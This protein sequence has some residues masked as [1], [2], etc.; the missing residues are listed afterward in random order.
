MTAEREQAVRPLMN[1][2]RQV[3]LRPSLRAVFGQRRPKFS[4]SD[5]FSRRRILL[6]ALGKGSIG[7]EA[8]QLLGSIVVSHLWQTAL[9]RTSVPLGHRTPVMIYIDE[10][11]DYLRLPGDLSE[12]LAQARGLGVGFTLANQE[13]GQLKQIR[14]AV[15]ANTRSRVYFQ[16]APDDARDLAASFGGELLSREDFRALRQYQAYAQ[17]LD[18]GS[19]TPWVSLTTQALPRP[20]R[21]PAL[22]RRRSREHYGQSLDLVETDLLSLTNQPA[23]NASRPSEGEDRAAGPNDSLEPLGRRRPASKR[24]Q[25]DEEGR[26]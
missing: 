2:L 14:S 25:T 13:L 12:A 16:L 10:V 17:L 19:T 24:P 23:R 5:V 1:K 9:G 21:D 7:P 11:Q 15:M 22:L 6:V 8:A 4:L 3:M 18:K 20:V 26:S